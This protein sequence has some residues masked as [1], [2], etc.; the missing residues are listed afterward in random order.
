MRGFFSTVATAKKKTVATAKIKEILWGV[1][2]KATQSPTA[3]QFFVLRG[4][5]EQIS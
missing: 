5:I 3:A 1:A 2:A 4:P